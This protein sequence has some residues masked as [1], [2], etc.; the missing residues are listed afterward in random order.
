MRE[1]DLHTHTD[2]SD[3][4]ESPENTVRHA[5][6]LG[7]RAIAVTDHDSI[8]GV[9]AAQKAGEK[10]GV[11]V[12]PG[13]E[14]T[15]GWYDKEVHILAYDLDPDSDRLPPVL[16]WVVE[17][18]NE[19]NRKMIDLL[20]R[21][22]I[23]IDLDELQAKHPNST[24][25]RPHFA[26][27]LIEEGIADSVT[28]AFNRFLDPGRKYYVRRHFLSLEDAVGLIISAGGKAVIA[29]PRQ[30]RISSESLT[31]LMQRGAAAGVSGLECFYSGYGPE[32][33]AKYLAM[34]EKYGFCPP[35]GSDWHGSH[36]P[37]IHMGS[38]IDGELCAPYEILTNLRAHK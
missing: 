36:K 34:A 19:R 17:D 22:G 12:V 13:M 5:K 32:D 30:Y 24:I 11:E 35:A 38:G 7:L 20:A 4:S 10:Y 37:H 18:R 6:E 15:C 27:C 3:G 8:N 31:E 1:I 33:N 23:M 9:K 28:D 14:L 16:S 29:H 25:G 2:I 26:M 21:D